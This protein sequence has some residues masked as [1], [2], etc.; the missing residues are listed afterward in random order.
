M[1]L[2][3]VRTRPPARPVASSRIDVDAA[4]GERVGAREAAEAGADDDHRALLV[5]LAPDLGPRLLAGATR[6]RGDRAGREAGAAGAQHVA[7]G[8]ARRRG[9]NPAR[10]GKPR[11]HRA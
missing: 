2:R 6:Q 5:D 1:N 7:R 4:V 10:V 3:S 11:R 9:R 8:S